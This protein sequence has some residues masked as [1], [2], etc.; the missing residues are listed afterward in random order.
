MKT[1][2]SSRRIDRSLELPAREYSDDREHARSAFADVGIRRKVRLFQPTRAPDK[3]A[4]WEEIKL[5]AHKMHKVMQE[6][7]KEVR[8]NYLEIV[9]DEPNRLAWRDYVQF[10]KDYSKELLNDGEQHTKSDSL[11]SA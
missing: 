9:V 4:V 10:K 8:T 1:N 7:L 6:I 2:Q 11:A 5:A 3:D